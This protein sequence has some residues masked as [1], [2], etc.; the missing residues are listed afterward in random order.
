MVIRRLIYASQVGRQVRYADAEQ[1]ADVAARRNREQGVT[2]IL[3]YTPSHFLQVLEGEYA[4]VQRTLERIRA[5]PRHSDLRV[6]SDIET[7]DREFG[8][9]AMASRFSIVERARMVQL[10]VIEALVLLRA[11]V[12][13]NEAR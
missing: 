4:A 3:L 1:I 13:A 5:D 7:G 2:G 9:W 10:D 8:A 11:A 12:I 6:I